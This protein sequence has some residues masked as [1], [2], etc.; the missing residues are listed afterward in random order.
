MKVMP[1]GIRLPR[2]PPAASVPST[3]RGLYRVFSKY[4]S[5]TEPM[6][7]AVATDEPAIAE[8]IAHETTLVWSRPPGQR[9]NQTLR[10]R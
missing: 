10:A 2:A 9:P 6:V 3:M 4:G 8:K 1:G 7:A 5:A